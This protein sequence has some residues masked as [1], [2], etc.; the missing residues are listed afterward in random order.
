MTNERWRAEWV[1]ALDA[2]EADVEA[3]EAL[4]MDDHQLREHPLADPWTPPVGLGPLP[5][6]LTPRAD[7]ILAR[8]L[9]ATKVLV[10]TIAVNRRQA[11]VMSRIEVGHQGTPR[12]AYV[13]QAL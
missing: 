9:S 12:P 7:A 1:A 13:D 5:L 6:D 4:I 8:Q 10:T 11:A 2:L 3:I